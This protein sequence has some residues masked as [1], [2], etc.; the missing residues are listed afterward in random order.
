MKDSTVKMKIKG[1]EFLSAIE[2]DIV[3]IALMMKAALKMII[4][5]EDIAVILTD[6]SREGN[7]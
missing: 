3:K 2:G 7:V 4:T 6:K 1:A 5:T